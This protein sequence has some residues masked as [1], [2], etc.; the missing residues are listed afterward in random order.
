MKHFT[1]QMEAVVLLSTFIVTLCG[2][3][4]ALV[5]VLNGRIRAW[6]VALMSWILWYL[7]T[8]LIDPLVYLWVLIIATLRVFLENLIQSSLHCFHR[9]RH[10]HCFWARAKILVAMTIKMRKSLKLTHNSA[11]WWSC[12]LKK[13]VSSLTTLTLCWFV[14]CVRLTFHNGMKNPGNVTPMLAL[15]ILSSQRLGIFYSF[16]FSTLCSYNFNCQHKSPIYG[17]DH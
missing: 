13:M 17:S 9:H 5:Q 1:E 4:E 12:A 15:T 8:L 10:H 14:P 3:M 2:Y 16:L 7:K 6:A 11:C